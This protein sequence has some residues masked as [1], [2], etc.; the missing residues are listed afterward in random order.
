MI[1][2]IETRDRK[3]KE[4]KGY[5][6][7]K[8][9]VQKSQRCIDL[10]LCIKLPVKN[11]P[12][13]QWNASNPF[14]FLIRHGLHLEECPVGYRPQ[15]CHQQWS[16]KFCQLKGL[17]APRCVQLRWRC[18]C[19]LWSRGA[20]RASLRRAVYR[21]QRRLVLVICKI[22]VLRLVIT[23]VH[24]RFGICFQNSSSNGKMD[25]KAWALEH[26]AVRSHF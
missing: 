24:N 14:V 6:Y 21:V 9:R 8:I 7:I 3:G 16:F 13:A 4:C 19:S 11:S 10:Y 5:R 22:S 26:Q 25:K 12:W 20:Q 18:W 2:Y 1:I 17:W 23:G 15:A